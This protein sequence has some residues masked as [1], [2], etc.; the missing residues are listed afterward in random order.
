[1]GDFVDAVKGFCLRRAGRL[2]AAALCLASVAAPAAACR[3]ALL[4]AMDVSA[5]VDSDEFTL[6]RNGLASALIAPE[7]EAA[8]LSSPDPVALAAFEW[9]GQWNQRVI[10]DWRLI[11]GPEDLLQA[12]EDLSVARRG[13]TGFPTSIGYALA[14]AAGLMKS[15]PDCVRHT[16]DLSG[17]GKNNHGFPPALAYQ[18]FPLGHVIV[19][20]LAIGG[21]IEASDLT[22]YYRR[23][24]IQGPNA[25][26]E[27]AQSHNDFE[28][29]MRRKLEREVS[30]LSI[31]RLEE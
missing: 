25:F 19:N 7:V 15:A 6:Q 2:L 31:T 12:A 17:D 5:S 8:F 26:V 24:V 20:A 10:L 21:A 30:T 23:E 18:N 29:A 9:S 27:V 22:A 1:M 16:I 14:Y 11:R 13:A 3:L 28:R 4:L